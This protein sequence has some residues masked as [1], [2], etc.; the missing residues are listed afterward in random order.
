MS[1]KELVLNIPKDD[2]LVVAPYMEQYSMNLRVSGNLPPG[3]FPPGKL[4]LV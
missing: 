1:L 4:F 2:I 3:K